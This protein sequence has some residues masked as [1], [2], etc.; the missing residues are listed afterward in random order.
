MS[1]PSRAARVAAFA[2]VALLVS[3]PA[4]AA[5]GA[6]PTA[7]LTDS[8][9]RLKNVAMNTSAKSGQLSPNASQSTLPST[10]LD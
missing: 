5:C 8:L 10:T 2:F 7:A 4:L 1:L 3:A 6:A 9:L